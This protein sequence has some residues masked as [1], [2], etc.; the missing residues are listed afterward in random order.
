MICT[1][2]VMV[3]LLTGCGGEPT[4]KPEPEPENDPPAVVKTN[5]M[6]VYM[7]YMPWFQS[8]E[9]SGYW[10][11]HWKMANKN[12]DIIT[13]GK[14]EIAAHYYPLIGP[15]DSKD[16]IVLEYHLLLM[17]YAGIDGLLID[18]YGTHNINDYRPIFNSTEILIEKAEEIGLQ[19]AIVYEE[20]TAE[21][22][23][24]KTSLTA[25][26]AAQADVKFLAEDYFT[27]RSYIKIDEEPLLMT[28]GPRYF[29]SSSQWTQI[30]QPLTTEIKFLPLW[31]HAGRVGSN[32]DGEFS[33]VD[34][35]PSLSELTT[36]YNRTISTKI[37]SAYGRFHDYYVEG[38]WGTSYGDVLSNDGESL[39]NTLDKA[40]EYNLDHLQLVTWNDFGEGTQIEPSVEDEY[41]FLVIIQEFTG[42]GYNQDVLEVIFTY[43]QKRKEYKGNV[44][45]ETQ[46]A[47]IYQ[48]LIDLKVEEAKAL[49]EELA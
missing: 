43:Y 30:F 11:S 39:R 5:S 35:E 18:W 19:F 1:L 31:N 32:G 3:G 25:I 7:H 45:A 4:P 10:G 37:G 14:R 24:S 21:I 6:K 41:Q 42:V 12:P 9:V 36:F 17:K 23:A 26:E 46:L 33:W 15:Y 22:V 49:L 48:H 28:F 8:K 34:F 47:K 40:Q 44:D 20:Y 29:N 16:P 2:L 13:G 38:G 27:K